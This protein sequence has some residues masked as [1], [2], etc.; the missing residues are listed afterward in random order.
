MAPPRVGTSGDASLIS[1][2]RPQPED[3]NQSA[4]I[5]GFVASQ[6]PHLDK[7]YRRLEDQFFQLHKAQ[8][9]GSSIPELL[10]IV[11]DKVTTFLRPGVLQASNSPA[12]AALELQNYR[13]PFQIPSPELL[14]EKMARGDVGE[15]LVRLTE[16]RHLQDAEGAVLSTKPSAW[17][18]PL[19]DVRQLGTNK[20]AYLRTLGVARKRE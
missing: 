20:E 16:T 19:D 9:Q 4:K 7:A 8:A 3:N 12:Q 1:S 17:M 6:T 2:L 15:F 11:N 5:A 13:G 10:S 18:A 14:Q